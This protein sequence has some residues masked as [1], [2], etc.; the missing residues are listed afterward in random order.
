VPE[1]KQMVSISLEVVSPELPEEGPP[2]PME[3][4]PTHKELTVVSI[5]LNDEFK[6]PLKQEKP[7]AP[8]EIECPLRI[9][10]YEV[11]NLSSQNEN[12]LSESFDSTRAKLGKVIKK[13]KVQSFKISINMKEK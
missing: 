4:T 7:A 6:I 2:T 8:E 5:P 12:S 9:P 13:K 10:N 1:L 3:K 11:S